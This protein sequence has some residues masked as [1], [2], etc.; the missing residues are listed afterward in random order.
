M[1]EKIDNKIITRENFRR[2]GNIDGITSVRRF[3]GSYYI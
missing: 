1:L 2:V 3:S